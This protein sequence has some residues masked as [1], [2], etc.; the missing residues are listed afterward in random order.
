MRFYVPK[1]ELDNL[2]EEEKKKEEDGQGEEGEGEDEGQEI[3]PAKVLCDK[4]VKAA[5]LGEFAGEVIASLSELNLLI[6][7]GKY[8]MDFFDNFLKL[9]GRT[10]DYKIL[11]KDIKKMFLLP[12][13]D[14]VHMVFVI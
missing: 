13:P 4:I 11:F 1:N 14:G 9:H 3:T 12:K 7:R 5:K 8:S 6:P 10:H 2:D